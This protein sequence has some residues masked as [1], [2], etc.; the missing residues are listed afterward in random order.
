MEI[1]PVRN[2]NLIFWPLANNLG[3][4]TEGQQKIK[5]VCT[6][7]QSNLQGS[8]QL[9]FS[10]SSTTLVLGWPDFSLDEKREGLWNTNNLT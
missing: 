7:E 4:L 6:N 3:K 10:L 9:I 5:I 8:C 2:Q 1:C